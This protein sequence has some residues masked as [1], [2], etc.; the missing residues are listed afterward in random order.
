MTRRLVALAAAFASMFVGAPARA[1][2]VGDVPLRPEDRAGV[3][4]STT[5]T[6][7]PQSKAVKTLAFIPA[8]A[9]AYRVGERWLVTADMALSMTSYRFAS[10]ERGGI[11]RLANPMLGVQVTAFAEGRLQLR[12]GATAGAPLV[13]VPGGIT[14]NAAAERAPSPP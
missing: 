3:S 1:S 7:S 8:L 5:A 9:G 10:Q 11:A 12:L 6:A 14:A 2:G 13:T 4:L